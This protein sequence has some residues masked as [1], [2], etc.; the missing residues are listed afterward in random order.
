[1]MDKPWTRERLAEEC[2]RAILDME[3]NPALIAAMPAS[4]RRQFDRQLATMK[5]MEAAAR[6]V[7][8]TIKRGSDEE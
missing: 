5:E 8:I 4:M 3:N 1:M 2:R 6:G 7:T